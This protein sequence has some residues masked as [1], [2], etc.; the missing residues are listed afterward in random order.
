MMEAGA[1]MGGRQDGGPETGPLGLAFSSINGRHTSYEWGWGPLTC[2]LHEASWSRCD[3][4]NPGV[5]LQLS[6][7]RVRA[8][9]VVKDA[10][11]DVWIRA[12]IAHGKCKN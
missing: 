3:R 5:L 6:G 2:Q 11:R 9:A 1:T 12:Q 10:L 7:P 8:A 4:G